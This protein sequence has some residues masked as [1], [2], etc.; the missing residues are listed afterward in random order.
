MCGRFTITIEPVFFQQELD[1]GNVPGEWTPRYNTAPT[2]N[3]PVV[4]NKDTRDVE[5]LRW[6]LI[7]F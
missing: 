1:L 2:Q 7:P 3:I 5:M 6:G 4:L